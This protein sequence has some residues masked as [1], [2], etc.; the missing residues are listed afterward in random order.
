MSKP[1]NRP[2]SISSTELDTA[3]QEGVQRAEKIEEMSEADLDGVTGGVGPTAG[4]TE[5]IKN[6]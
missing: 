1:V 5:P 3:V 2:E 4:M 6:L